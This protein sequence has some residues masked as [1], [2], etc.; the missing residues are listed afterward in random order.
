M[1][2]LIYTF[3]ILMLSSTVFSAQCP[4]TITQGTT[5]Q[6]NPVVQYGITWTM[7]TDEE[8]GQFITGDYFVIDDGSVTIS[9][10][11]PAWNGTY[12]GSQKNPDPSLPVES[13]QGVHATADG[14]G[15]ALT[16]TFPVSLAAGD[17]LLSTI[18]NASGS[19]TNWAGI[20]ESYGFVETA[21]ILTVL[22]VDPGANTFRPSS[23]DRAQR[24][25]KTT[26]INPAHFPG[27]STVGITLPS[28]VGFGV[29][30]YFER[31]LQRPWLIY[32]WDFYGRQIHPMQSMMG[33]HDYVGTFLGEAMV[34]MMSD[35]VTTTAK[36]G[37]VQVLIDYC[38]TA[39]NETGDD[40]DSSFWASLM[41]VGGVI[42]GD[43]DVYNWFIDNP[44]YN[45]D[46]DHE[47]FFYPDEN[48]YWDDTATSAI[49]PYGE[50][51]TGYTHPVTGKA[52]MYCKD[53]TA[54]YPQLPYYEHLHPSEW[55][56]ADWSFSSCKGE[57]YR[58]SA[59]VAPMVG[60]TLS[61]R[62]IDSISAIDV[63]SKVRCDACVDYMDRWM[64][65][66]YT[67]NEYLSTGR[68]FFEEMNLYTVTTN[69]ASDYDSSGSAFVDDMWDT[70]RVSS[71]I[72]GVCGDETAQVDTRSY[73]C[74]TGA[75]IN[76]IDNQN[77]TTW[78]CGPAG[79]GTVTD[80]CSAAYSE[81]PGGVVTSVFSGASV[82]W[83]N[84]SGESWGPAE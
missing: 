83:V 31:G 23:S 4:T 58:G 7:S 69:E 17:A 79:G 64:D 25:I 81:T 41:A 26:D 63:R 39:L 53:Q 80:N 84:S 68:T 51:W 74:T 24:T 36:N 47:K 56:C 1:R 5:I 70:Y 19:Q 48:T 60:M 2:L 50:A 62:T 82:I 61:L 22:S 38:Y 54:Q 72:D 59:E 21:S 71:P 20:A 77:T 37:F 29:A 57:W 44:T 67:T 45:T 3:A 49:I 27:L 66:G 73:E 46:R 75:S 40:L 30:E 12:N 78:D 11:F 42:L 32:G 15:A 33:Y 16:T 6:C 76:H 18:G 13:S 10:V 8:V 35:Q 52:P 65:E 14:Y 28:H 34:F 55:D 43:S 9:S